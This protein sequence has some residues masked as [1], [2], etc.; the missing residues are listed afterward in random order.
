[1]VTTNR[2]SKEASSDNFLVSMQESL[3]RRF[4]GSMKSPEPVIYE[5][6]SDKGYLHQYYRLRCQLF[7]RDLMTSEEIGADI[8]DKISEILIARRGRLVIGACRL[9]VREGDEQFLLPMEEENFQLRKVFPHLPLNKERHAVISKF[10]ILEEHRQLDILQGL[11]QVMFEKVIAS[12]IHYLFARGRNYVL[13]RNWR[14]IANSFGAK[15]TQICKDVEMPMD[16]N[17]P[18]EKPVLTFSDLS[19]LCMKEHPRVPVPTS[20]KIE[21]ITT[22]E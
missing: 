15:H 4:K 13:A 8:H 3:I 19:A 10:A 11:C 14:L 16:P 17:F 6:T 5:F 20:R 12:D 9:T 22:A 2:P 21:L 7:G 1:M 18:E